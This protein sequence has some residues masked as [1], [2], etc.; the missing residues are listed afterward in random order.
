[1]PTNQTR[2]DLLDRIK[3][4]NFPGSIIDV[5]KAADQGI[6]LISEYEQKQQQEQEMKV[7][8]TPEEQEIGLREEHARGNTEASMAFPDV[9]PGASFNTV[10]MKAPIDIQKIDKQ[11]HLVESYK[12][13]PP[14]IQDLPTGPYEGTI[15]ESP[16][17]Y[18]KG[19]FR[20]YQYG[21][22][23]GFG[24]KSQ[25]LGGNTGINASLSP[26][27]RFSTP[28]L[29][30]GAIRG[31]RG[32]GDDRNIFTG[33][34][35]DYRFGT[36]Q[37][38]INNMRDYDTRWM[39]S[40]QGELGHGFKAP[41][42]SYPSTT[43]AARI[44]D[45]STGNVDPPTEVP[46]TESS[47]G[48]NWPNI[49][50]PKGLDA[51]ARL[52]LGVGRPGKAGCFGGMCYSAPIIPWNLS[53]FYEAGTK[54]SLRPG[55]HVGI[56]GRLGPVTGEYNYNLATK[57]PGFQVGLNI[58]LFNRKKKT[59]GLRKM[60]DGGNPIPEVEISAL[61]D[62]S[63]NKLSDAQKQ[64]YDTYTLPSKDFKQYMPFQLSDRTEGHIHWKDAINMVDK[65]G[66]GNIYNKPLAS[67]DKWK[68]DEH[69]HFRAHAQSSLANKL[70]PFWE[71]PGLKSLKPGL[72][73]TV[74]DVFRKT[75]PTGDIAIPNLPQRFKKSYEDYQYP[76]RYPISEE[77][78]WNRRDK[79]Y[80]RQVPE[81]MRTLFAELAHI[82]PE[83]KTKWSELTTPL[84]RLS[85]SIREGES[86]DDS[87]YQSYFDHEYHTHYGPN[88]SERALLK[89]SLKQP[90][91]TVSKYGTYKHKDGGEKKSKYENLI[92]EIEISA[93]SKES[94]DKLSD[95]EKQVYDIYSNDGNFQ[96]YAP[97]ILSDMSKGFL[98]WKDALNMIKGS[99]VGNIHNYSNH[100]NLPT[101][102][103]GHFRPHA[104]P[105]VLSKMGYLKNLMYPMLSKPFN[106]LENKVL[107]GGNIHIPKF[108]VLSES[109]RSNLENMSWPTDIKHRFKQQ[110][111]MNNLIAELAHINPNVKTKWSQITQVPSRLYRTIEERAMPD[112][113]NYKSYW[114]PEYHTHYGPN[115]SERGLIK[116]YSKEPYSQIDISR[117]YG[118]LDEN[119]NP[120][121]YNVE[122]NPYRIQWLR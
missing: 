52:S 2:R 89:Q 106:I 12:G 4:S 111:Y 3:L 61:S 60:E 121:P 16:S 47:G 11:G 28:N 92:P 113:S 114:D 13:V 41:T 20:K 119:W 8:N 48:I 54:H 6:D 57:K 31:T 65:S 62:K 105:N 117:N 44:F 9:Q 73:G 39:G 122:W 7:A 29:D 107:S 5:F 38:K 75:L 88:S 17:G 100:K 46:A 84:S 59:G 42:T 18:Q 99:R 85:R 82:D 118:H 79:E 77:E 58:P 50:L 104:V 66:V 103:E 87:N 83:A 109:D 98:H 53:G 69:G 115:S 26:T 74:D 10:G 70:T 80:E 102:E 120:I 101:N 90:Y 94:Y 45:P 95:N 78:F 22:S 67:G 108:G 56:S 51:S 27:Y 19:G 81:Y 71:Y 21:G 68:M 96:Q 30:I 25:V 40:F 35:M 64:V 76:D 1:M 24:L 32:W 37:W 63:Y 72:L 43:T 49:K 93:L 91:S 15:I 97:Y 112:R 110:L 36:P 86:P 55:Q 33:A 14:G 23:S 34:N 116:R